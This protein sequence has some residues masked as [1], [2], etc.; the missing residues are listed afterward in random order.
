[1]LYIVLLLVYLYPGLIMMDSI[2]FPGEAGELY[3]L[4]L[5]Y[6]GLVAYLS[7]FF[8][9]IW[10]L[11]SKVLDKFI[12]YD[13][14]VKKHRVLGYISTSSILLHP[15][16]YILYNIHYKVPISIDP[17][18]AL[19][20][21]GL[22]LALVV[23]VT[24]IFHRK[25]SYE[26]WKRIHWISFP[27]FSFIFFHTISIGSDIYGIHKTIFTALWIIHLLILLY[28]PLLELNLKLNPS[29]VE[30]VNKENSE[31]TTLFIKSKGKF[32]PG[33]FG[34]LKYRYLGKWQS[35]HPF[36]ISSKSGG[37]DISFTIKS[38]G[39]F[40]SKINSISP[41]DR[42][43]IDYPYGGFTLK[44]S[45]DRVVFI[46]G[47]VGITP[48]H[49][50]ISSLYEEG[51]DKEVV[52]IYSVNYLKELLF[53]KEF[54]TI[55]KSR[56]NWTLKYVVSMEDSPYFHGFVTPDKLKEYSNNTLEGTFYLCGPK[57][58][59]SPLKKFLKGER[60]PKKDI[61][62]EEFLFLP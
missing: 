20:S 52:L 15:T 19:G 40:T 56:P 11:K 59:V 36:S 50:M 30:R 2:Y 44:G 16:F 33:Q 57:A 24:S 37:E 27:L 32:T 21:I 9:Y 31:V 1:M 46:A 45:R 5:R 29:M 14:R 43:L 8:Q 49:S 10:T 58:M 39:D 13:T 48:I 61:R 53:K 4:L 35:W 7:L 12:P 22:N 25:L 42:V 55:F 34:F 41:G 51:Q 17:Y 47:G 23:I 3:Y 62:F 18:I 28:K 60:K 38:L 54:D 26:I 6:F